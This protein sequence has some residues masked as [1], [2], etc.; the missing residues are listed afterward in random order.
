MEQRNEKVY[1][2]TKRDMVEEYENKK[3]QLR[4]LRMKSGII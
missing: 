1:I 3:R 4:M 2:K